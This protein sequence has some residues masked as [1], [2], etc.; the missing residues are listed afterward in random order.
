MRVLLLYQYLNHRDTVSALSNHLNSLGVEIECLDLPNLDYNSGRAGL[1]MF[2]R[3]FVKVDS[4]RKFILS[5]LRKYYIISQI[6]KYDIIDIHSYSLYYNRVIP[7][8]KKRGKKLIIMI[9]GSDFYRASEKELQQKK[10]GFDTADII[11]VESEHVKEDFL[12]IF[13][14]YKDKI[15]IVQFGLNQLDWLKSSMK[16]PLLNTTLIENDILR[17]KLIVTCGYN[18]FRA[19]QHLIIIDAI[20]KLPLEYKKQIHIVIPFTYGGDK[21]YEEELINALKHDS[22]TYTILNKRLSDEQLVELRR[23]SNIAIN[24]QITDSFSAS[25]QEHFM[26]GSVQIIGDWLPYDVFYNKGL[27]AVRTSLDNLAF[28]IDEVVANYAIYSEKC[29]NNSD[30]IYRFSSW[31]YVTPLWVS[32][33]KKCLS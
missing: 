24:I 27:Y 22:V 11:H 30:I 20:G 14:E 16:T 5:V 31:K 3:R 7:A 25:I 2:L 10:L 1:S 13:P 29:K 8:I 6:N 23:I 12:R 18:G 28:N 4:V 21:E 26:A 19:Q 32:M 9:W 33:Y 15:Y 17:T